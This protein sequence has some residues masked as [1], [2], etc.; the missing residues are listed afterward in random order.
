MTKILYIPAGVWLTYSKWEAEK[1]IS[2]IVCNSNPSPA[3][4]D[5]KKF[6]SIPIDRPILRSEFEIFND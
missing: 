5:W 2:A 4:N 3:M 1:L 6:N